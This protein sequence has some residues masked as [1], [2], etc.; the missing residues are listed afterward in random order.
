M[1]FCGDY[2][3]PFSSQPYEWCKS[4]RNAWLYMLIDDLQDEPY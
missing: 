1:E 4:P 3:T 2:T